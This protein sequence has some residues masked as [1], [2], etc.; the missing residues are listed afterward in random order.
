MA[1]YQ[2]KDQ[3][4]R[5][6]QESRL[7]RCPYPVV[8]LTGGIATGKSTVAKL[9]QQAGLTVID[10]DQLVKA[11]YSWRETQQQLQELTAPLSF[12]S[13]GQVDFPRL[14]HWAFESPQNRQALENLIY[15]QLP[16]AFRDK[17]QKSPEE[18]VFIYDVPLLF[19]KKLDQLVDL[20]VCV[21]ASRDIQL[22]R[23][24]QRDGQ[25]LDRAE[26][27][28]GQQMDIQKKRRLTD[29]VIDNTKKLQS[30]NG[31][32]LIF[33]ESYFEQLD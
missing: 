21:Y 1:R 13:D 27:I 4:I 24:Q 25:T 14:R 6:T 19:E 5:L 22:Q 2:L 33:L 20:T 3:Y 18:K 10:A 11:I 7:H 28:L 15:P 23:L 9:L 17:I 30:L 29:V 12:I 26:K 16:E 8:G 32:I 31:Q